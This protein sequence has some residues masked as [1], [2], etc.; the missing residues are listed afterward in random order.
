M[1]LLKRGVVM[2]EKEG[3][4]NTTTGFWADLHRH[5]LSQV[6]I[7]KSN[8][9][10]YTLLC[11]YSTN[12]DYFILWDTLKEATN[13]K[14]RNT[15]VSERVEYR[16]WESVLKSSCTDSLIICMV[17]NLQSSWRM[18]C[19]SLYVCEHTYTEDQKQQKFSQ[20][21]LKKP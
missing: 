19:T 3:K 17:H 20:E 21:R 16:K 18:M 2:T 15:K 1:T 5:T 11:Y 13:A 4:V 14:L 10:W 7:D 12:V 6:T 8:L 9:M